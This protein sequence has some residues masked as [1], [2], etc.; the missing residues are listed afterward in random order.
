MCSVWSTWVPSCERRK[1]SSK[2]SRFEEPRRRRV[3]S[4]PSWY[5][6]QGQKLL[7]RVRR[8]QRLHG[9]SETSLEAAFADPKAAESLLG[10]R[11]SSGLHYS[12]LGLGEQ[13]GAGSTTGPK[14][15]TSARGVGTEAEQIAADR[16]VEKAQHEAEQADA[17]RAAGKT[18][19][20]GSNPRSEPPQVRRGAGGTTLQSGSFTSVGSHEEAEHTALGPCAWRQQT[21]A[22]LPLC[23]RT[24]TPFS[25]SAPTALNPDGAIPRGRTV[26]SVRPAG[27]SAQVRLW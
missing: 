20:S 12:G 9:R 17:D 27:N 10:G 19:F 5:E 14:G 4:S 22:R 1:T 2:E 13:A 3:T 16:Y 7:E 11:L 26:P 15:S 6:T 23:G 18:G 21:T 24:G 8:C 25:S